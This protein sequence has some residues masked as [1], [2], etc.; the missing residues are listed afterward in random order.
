VDRTTATSSGT[1]VCSQ[2]SGRAPQLVYTVEGEQ[3]TAVGG[4]AHD[5]GGPQPDEQPPDLLA[6]EL[7][8][9]DE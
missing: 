3:I 1:V 9:A 5:G 4:G 7:G 6:D 2:A 8:I